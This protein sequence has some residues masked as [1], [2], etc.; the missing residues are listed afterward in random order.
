M[1]RFD[2]FFWIYR[3]FTSHVS[4][5]DRNEQQGFNEIDVGTGGGLI[6]NVLLPILKRNISGSG[7]LHYQV[8]TTS[9][10]LPRGTDVRQTTRRFHGI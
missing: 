10:G 5:E 6:Q 9:S 7:K 8:S 4:L 2:R 3:V 1:K